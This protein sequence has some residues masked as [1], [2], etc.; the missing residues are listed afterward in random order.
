MK[1][2]DA[3]I[4]ILMSQSIIESDAYS[5]RAT[6]V[7]MSMASANNGK[8][9]KEKENRGYILHKARKQD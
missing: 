5:W 2:E 9:K 1:T 4:W 3:W 8:K 7:L 6:L